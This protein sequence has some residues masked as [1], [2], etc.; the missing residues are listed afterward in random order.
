[1]KNLLWRD[2]RDYKLDYLKSID[3]FCSVVYDYLVELYDSGVR[4]FREFDNYD[5]FLRLYSADA[6]DSVMKYLF[7]EHVSFRKF[8]DEK[9]LYIYIYDK[10]NDIFFDRY[11]YEAVSRIMKKMNL[12]TD[13]RELNPQK[14]QGNLLKAVIEEQ[15]LERSIK[16]E[17]AEKDAAADKQDLFDIIESCL[18][19]VGKKTKEEIYSMYVWEVREGFV[20]IQTYEYYRL[21]MGG[22]FAGTVNLTGTE[23]GTLDWAKDLIN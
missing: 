10:E 9:T 17:K 22:Y 13:K 12:L 7:G 23:K 2:A 4:N 16:R 8:I 11:C 1:M 19:W 14:M 21:V 20:R 18:C 15:R 5:L 6:H 3:L